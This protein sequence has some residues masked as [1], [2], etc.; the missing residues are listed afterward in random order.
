LALDLVQIAATIAPSSIEKG[1]WKGKIKP[2]P[3]AVALG[4]KRRN[5][6]G[7]NISIKPMMAPMTGA[8]HDGLW[9]IGCMLLDAVLNTSATAFQAWA[10]GAGN[11]GASPATPLR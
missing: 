11:F 5:L 8:H 1:Y 10:E 6:A 9:C 3:S 7:A 4:R 2:R